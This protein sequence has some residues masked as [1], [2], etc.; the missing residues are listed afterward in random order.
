MKTNVRSDVAKRIPLWTTDADCYSELNSS[1]TRVTS[2]S[3][4]GHLVRRAALILAA[5]LLPLGALA[6]ESDDQ[7]D[8]DSAR[9]FPTPPYLPRAAFVGTYIKTAVTP[10][11]RFQWEFTLLQRRVDA[12]VLVLE[13]GG[14]YGL[15]LPNNLGPSGTLAMTRLYQLTALAGVGYR[16]DEP[17]GWHWGVQVATGPLFYGSRF[18]DSST[19]DSVWPM[20]EARAQIG[21][22]AGLTVYGIAIGYALMYP[23]LN[24]TNTT[25]LLGGF[26]VGVFADRR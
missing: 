4:V 8:L 24:Q 9:S 20:V 10:Q 16:A 5:V 22:R 14:G 18:N 23:G 7:N 12:L 13:G 6:Q 15:A 11:L 1:L 26:M 19:E 3:G 25:P 2:N 21:L 17:G